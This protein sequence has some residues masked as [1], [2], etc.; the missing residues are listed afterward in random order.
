M[1]LRS[2]AEMMGQYPIFLSSSLMHFE[3][4]LQSQSAHSKGVPIVTEQLSRFV[5]VRNE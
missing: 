4:P 3:Y 1:A 2:T 5:D